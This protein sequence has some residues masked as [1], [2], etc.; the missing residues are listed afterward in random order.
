V[1]LIDDQLF[2]IHFITD[3]IQRTVLAP[4]VPEY[5]VPGSL[6][7]TFLDLRLVN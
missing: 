4:S 1:F 6:I 2:R 7:S 5:P 3:I